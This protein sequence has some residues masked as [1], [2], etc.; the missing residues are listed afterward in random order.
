MDEQ[1]EEGAGSGC[2]RRRVSVL[3][4]YVQKRM[5]LSRYEHLRGK[6]IYK[7]DDPSVLGIMHPLKLLFI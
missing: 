4:G 3:K 1:S 2:T 5:I 6:T 7:L